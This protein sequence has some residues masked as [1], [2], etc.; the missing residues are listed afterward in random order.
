MLLKAGYLEYQPE[1]G[2]Y[3]LSASVVT[4]GFGSVAT[5]YARQLAREKMQRFAVENDLV[6]VLAVRDGLNIACQLVLRGQGSLTVRLGEGSRIALPHGAMGRAW[7]ASLPPREREALW[8]E[9]RKG[10]PNAMSRSELDE[11][12]RQ[13]TKSGFCTALSKLEPD[14]LGAATVLQLP[15]EPEP[16]VL[17]CAVPAFRHAEKASQEALGTRLVGLRDEML[18]ASC[19]IDHAQEEG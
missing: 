6:V 9:V 4:L 19:A 14:L 11:A 13:F 17:G 7:M 16:C 15:G 10:Y 3:R 5:S 18:R 8:D 1:R 2:Q 12:L